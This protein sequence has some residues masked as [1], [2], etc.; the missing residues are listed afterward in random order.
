MSLRFIVI[1][2]ST[3][4]ASNAKAQSADVLLKDSGSMVLA[5]KVNSKDTNSHITFHCAATNIT[6]NPLV[7]ID[8]KRK[9]FEDIQNLNPDTVANLY[10]FRGKEAL[11][12]FG[13]KAKYGAIVIELKKS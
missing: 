5:T 8:G 2:I 13:R 7:I 6:Q 12:K 10:V 9:A 3:L 4:F 1:L 11:K